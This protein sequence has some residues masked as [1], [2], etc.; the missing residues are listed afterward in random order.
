[1][2]TSSRVTLGFAHYTSGQAGAP[3]APV[4]SAT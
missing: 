4:I 1:M 2:P 3:D